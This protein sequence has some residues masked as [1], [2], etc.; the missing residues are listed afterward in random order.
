MTN[1]TQRTVGLILTSGGTVHA[2]DLDTNHAICGNRRYRSFQQFAISP[3]MY[4][5]PAACPRCLEL[6]PANK[7]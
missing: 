2:I 1:T 4:P 7:A 3:G 5:S 6:V